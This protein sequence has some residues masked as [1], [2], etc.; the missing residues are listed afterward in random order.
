MY[1]EEEKPART[2]TEEVEARAERAT[3]REAPAAAREEA[4]RKDKVDDLASEGIIVI[5]CERKRGRR[6]EWLGKGRS[7]DVTQ[8]RVA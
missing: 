2:A 4:V 7:D 6:Q 8:T 5:L 1:E 3:L